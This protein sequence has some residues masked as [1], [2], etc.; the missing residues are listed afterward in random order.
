MG[1]G[2]SVGVDVEVWVGV[3]LGV[4]VGVEVGVEVGV[5]V[6]V[7]VEV[8]VGVGVRVSFNSPRE[9]AGSESFI[10]RASVNVGELNQNSKPASIRSSTTTVD[11]CDGCGRTSASEGM[12]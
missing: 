2:V 6:A 1:L 3:G 12:G 9:M 11:E 10:A 7:G 4:T 8:A 5:G